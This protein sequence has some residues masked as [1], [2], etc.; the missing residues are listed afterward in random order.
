M[1]YKTMILELI[2][3]RPTLY[4]QLRSSKRL[5]PTID[6]YAIELKARHEDWKE[7]LS[8][9]RPGRDRNQIASE[10]LELAIEEFQNNRLPS[11]S[12]DD[13]A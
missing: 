12:A 3:D 6:A 1:L 7:L 13:E 8:Q 11:E 5:L 10:A 9:E 4:E 2:Q